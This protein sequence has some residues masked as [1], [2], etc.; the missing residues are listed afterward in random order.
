MSARKPSKTRRRKT[1]VGGKRPGKIA[2]SGGGELT[3]LGYLFYLM[4]DETLPDRQRMA[5]A[6]KLAPYFHA[7]LKP[8]RAG[9]L[10]YASILN[11]PTDIEDAVSDPDQRKRI[12]KN[13]FGRFD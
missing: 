3:P 4:N 7:K 10:P 13:I 5:I 11:E 2:V 12:R 6:K 8:V 9:E 1:S